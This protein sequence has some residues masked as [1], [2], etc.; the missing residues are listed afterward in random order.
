MT[1][2]HHHAG[3]RDGERHDVVRASLHR[4][5]KVQAIDAVVVFRLRFDVHFLEPRDRTIGRRLQHAHVGRAIFERADE[6]FGVARVAD[7]VAIGEGDAIRVVIDHLQRR[8]ELVRLVRRQRDLLAVAERHLTVG[9]GAIGEHLH[10]DV[11]AGRRVDVAAVGFRARREAQ[12]GGIGVMD[13]DARHA[14]RNRDRNVVGRRRHR[15]GDDA[16]RERRADRRQRQAERAGRVARHLGDAPAIAV[17]DLHLRDDRRAVAHKVRLNRERRARLHLRIPRRHV[18]ADAIGKQRQRG[19]VD[20]LT[21]RTARREQDDP[22]R[23]R[24]GGGLE[25]GAAQRLA[26]DDRVDVDRRRPARGVGDHRVG[27]Q[28]RVLRLR[29]VDGGDEP[30]AQRRRALFDVARDLAV[31]GNATERREAP[32]QRAGGKHRRARRE[33]HQRD[34]RAVGP[35]RGHQG[36][37]DDERR[38][39]RAAD[40]RLQRDER[41]P[42]RPHA[43]DQFT[44]RLVMHGVMPFDSTGC[45]R[46]RAGPPSL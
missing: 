39:E 10:A 12:A 38:D 27:K 20:R 35:A 8:G 46:R 36:G 25:P 29:D 15:A 44:N 33:H 9:G 28:W 21:R 3:A 30:I 11:G 4:V 23:Q 34:R 37:T 14:R 40:Q 5:H 16:V 42:P 41:A 45:L 31:R 32:G 17:R 22:E 43:I 26:R 24:G 7:A 19:G 6:I 1:A 2:V 18:Q 13:V